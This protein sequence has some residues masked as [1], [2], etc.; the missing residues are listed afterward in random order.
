MSEEIKD[1]KEIEE[2]D[3]SSSIPVLEFV[4]K[5]YNVDPIARQAPIITDA[6]YL[7]KRAE[8]QRAWY[9]KKASYN[10]KRYKTYKK[11]EII[12]A[13]SIPVVISFSATGL[14]ENTNLITRMVIENGVQKEVSLLSLATIFQF[15]A[16]TAGV[17]L[18]IMT[19]VIELES[20]YNNWIEYRDMAEK[21]EREKMLYVTRTEPYDEPNAYPMFVEK[22]EG[23]LA[24]EIQKWKQIPRAQMQTELLDKAQIAIDKNKLNKQDKKS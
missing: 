5:G 10:Q 24:K 18:V 20:Y 3:E 17:L 21:L 14:V 12:L 16:A 6:E 8:N 22:I 1:S 9:D 4:G 11:W 15:M 19:K 2:K 7:E 13:A 23:L